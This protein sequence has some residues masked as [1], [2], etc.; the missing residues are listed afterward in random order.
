MTNTDFREMIYHGLTNQPVQVR[1]SFA[2][3]RTSTTEIRG[4]IAIVSDITELQRLENQKEEF[5]TIASH[6]LKTPITS[7]KGL[8]QLAIRRLNKAGHDL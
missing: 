8:T 6:E 4:G 5:L 7:I 1:V 2:P 3:I